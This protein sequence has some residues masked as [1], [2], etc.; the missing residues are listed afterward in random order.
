MEYIES[1]NPEP[2]VSLGLAPHISESARVIRS[3]LGVYTELGDYTEFVE[4][5]L[6]DFS[7]IMQRS[8]VIY[9]KIGKFVNIASD[10]RINPGN[11]PMQWVSQHHFMYR[12][13]QYGFGDEDDKNFFEGR[14]K[15]QVIIGHDVWIGHGVT[16][17]PGIH[18]GNGAI[19]GAGAVVTHDVPSYSIVAGIPGKEI[20]HRFNAKIR[21][22]IERTAWWDW[23]HTTIR[24]RVE[25]FR[26]VNRFIHLYG[27]R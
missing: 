5:T 24:E 10:V 16:I 6:G 23:D 27:E 21:E 3:E 7:Y 20:R 25:D 8:S 18:I 11:H 17:L 13:K 4:S 19:V 26:D 14:R 9:C 1:Y 15:K 2:E 22:G 12:R